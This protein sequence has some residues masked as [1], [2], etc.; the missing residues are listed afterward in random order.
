MPAT[1]AAA[2]LLK[3][4]TLESVRIDGFVVWFRLVWFRLLGGSIGVLDCDRAVVKLLAAALGEWVLLWL[5]HSESACYLG[6]LRPFAEA[7]NA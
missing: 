2:R 4:R 1:L 7:K 5:R 3:R 6:E